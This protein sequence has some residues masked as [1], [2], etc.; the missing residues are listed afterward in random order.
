MKKVFNFIASY[1]YD[2]VIFCMYGVAI[3]II[4]GH[5][6]H[7]WLM[8]AGL[9][10]KFSFEAIVVLMIRL[11]VVIF[12]A[13]RI[14][15]LLFKLLFIDDMAFVKADALYFFAN[16]ALII[17]MSELAIVDILLRGI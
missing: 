9:E 2:A 8:L 7:G 1:W 16:F 12:I 17:Y 14:G 5:C 10:D 4:G 13:T 15:F 6:N 11:V 3:F